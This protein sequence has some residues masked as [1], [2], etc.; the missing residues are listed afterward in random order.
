MGVAVMLEELD[1]TKKRV[2]RRWKKGITDA[3]DE[4]LLPNFRW[5]AVLRRVGGV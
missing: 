1:L 4:N 3:L 2:V 5:Y